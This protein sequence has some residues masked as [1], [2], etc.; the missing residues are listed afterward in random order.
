MIELKLPT[1]LQGTVA[2]RL[3]K[4][5]TTWWAQVETWLNFPLQ[6]MDVETCTLGILNLIAWQRDIQRF[7]GEPE[8]LYRLRVKYAY[9]NAKDAGSVAGIKRIFER[10]GVGYVEVEERRPGEDWDV[11][12]L[13]LADT[14]LSQNP[15]L[16]RVLMR[17]YGRT[18]RRY[19]FETLTSLPVQIR[20]FEFNHHQG[21]DLAKL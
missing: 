8:W 7:D 5:A 10:L 19:Q 14:Q 9:A 16:L 15:E 2:T 18:C 13:H 11:I 3:K 12:Y 21:N 17:M 20:S 6:Q 1:W 4:A